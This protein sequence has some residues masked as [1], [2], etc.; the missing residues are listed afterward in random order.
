MPEIFLATS[1]FGHYSYQPIKLL[2][3]QNFTHKENLIGR[4]LLP[5]EIVTSR[6]LLSGEPVND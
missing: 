2:E 1:S 4:K 3:E 6:M 5:D